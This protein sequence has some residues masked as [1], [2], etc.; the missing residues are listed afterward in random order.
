M[1]YDVTPGG[2]WSSLNPSV[3]SIGSS[4]GLMTGVSV[5]TTIITYTVGASYVIRPISVYPFAPTVTGPSSVCPGDTIILSNTVV[6]GT[7]TSVHTSIAE[8][9]MSGGLTLDS[10]QIVGVSSGTDTI[11]YTH[12]YGCPAIKVITVGGPPLTSSLTPPSICSGELFSYVPTSGVGGVTFNWVRPYI[13]GISLPAGAGT[14]NPTEVLINDSYV[15]IA[16]D[17]TYTMTGGGCTNTQVVTV[18]VK[19]NPVLSSPLTATICDS[20]IFNYTPTSFTPGTIFSWNRA[21]VIGIMNPMASGAGNPNEHLYNSSAWQIPV[22]YVYVM[23]NDGCLSTQTVTVTVNPTPFLTSSLALP[24]MCDTV[25]VNYIPTSNTP[26]FSVAWMRPAVSGIVPA[27]SFGSDAIHDA[28]LDTTT[29]V[30]QVIYY[31]RLSAYGC[32]NSFVQAVTVNVM[33]C[34]VE[35]GVPAVEKPEISV[36]PNPTAGKVLV[37]VPL[38]EYTCRIVNTLGQTVVTHRE[39]GPAFS[40]DLSAEPAGLYMLNISSDKTTTVFKVMKE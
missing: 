7:W 20:T 13:P 21:A 19:P 25:G 35:A 39:T 36:L 6:G 28:I 17:Y 8:V 22:N 24:D 9:A 3:L 4:T 1:A 38:G 31:L 37:S 2:T 40:L 33:P 5:G 26:V 32:I 23:T 15:P 30:I 14:G 29:G 11:I 16:V 18:I 34:A 12:P 10:A 27:N